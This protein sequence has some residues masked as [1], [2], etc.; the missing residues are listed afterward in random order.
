MSPRRV[1]VLAAV[2]VVL[3]A[4]GVADRAPR[5][6]RPAPGARTLMP[7]AA[8]PGALSSSWFCA[9]ATASAG[10][11]ADGVV[12]MANPTTRPAAGTVRVVPVAGPASAVAVR[13][14]PGSTAA[15]VLRD[16]VAAPHAAAVVD[17]DGG[18][19]TAELVVRGPADSDVVPCASRGSGRWYFADG[20]TAKDATLLLSLFNPFPEDAIVD[21]S[22]A[23]DQGRAAPAAFRPV[24]VPG[25]GLTVVDVGQH[26]R[27]REA[28]ATAAVARTGRVVAAQTQ[29]RT[30]P[31]RAGLSVALGAPS[32]GTEWHFADGVVADGVGERLAVANPG[33]A[34]ATVLFEPVLDEGVAEPFERTV[35]AR[36][37]ID[38]V[39]DE[40][41]GVP[42]G[43]GHSTSVRSL[44]G[45]PVVASRAVEVTTAGRP[46]R[47]DVLGA[48]RAATR[49]LFAAGG[50]A[51]P[52]EEFLVLL[53]PGTRPARVTVAVL[54][55][56]APVP[57]DGLGEITLAPGR[58]R[59]VRVGAHAAH[60][61]LALLVTSSAPVVADRSLSGPGPTGL[62]AGAGIPLG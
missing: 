26:V 53:N 4:G 15:V 60:P 7:T 39:L 57:L 55:P 40:A 38:V 20:S 33:P 29:L 44:D 18:Q 61:S 43:V 49:W 10:G 14:E 41:V 12:V 54:G 52:L 28:V 34:E 2:F 35:P 58:R 17:L 45:V 25:R 1:V 3:A 31:G 16:V 21:L 59:G 42:R 36:G 6:G 47:A 24:V 46:G 62:W 5:P 11:A 51:P 8:P 9:G 13:V 48:R 23:T 32:T 27:R 56:G 50:A 30:A 22:F 37:R 19:V